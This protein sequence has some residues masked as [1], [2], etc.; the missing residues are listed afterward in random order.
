MREQ[1]LFVA[2]SILPEGQDEVACYPRVLEEP[3][4][5]AGG[6]LVHQLGMSLLRSPYAWDL[7]PPPQLLKAIFDDEAASSEQE[8]TIE[9]AKL[10]GHTLSLTSALCWSRRLQYTEQRGTPVFLELFNSG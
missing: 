6:P 1:S 8:M 10:A 5:D 7:Q 2:L 3:G 4:G 9:G